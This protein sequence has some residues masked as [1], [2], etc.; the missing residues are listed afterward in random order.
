MPTGCP[1]GTEEY[2]EDNVYALSK[3]PSL[4]DETQP[5][6]TIRDCPTGTEQMVGSTKHAGSDGQTLHTQYPGPNKSSKFLEEN[7]RQNRSH[8][9]KSQSIL[10]GR[11]GRTADG[12]AEGG[13]RRMT[14]PTDRRLTPPTDRA[15]AHAH[16]ISE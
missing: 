14:P 7:H 10:D 8:Q 13:Q 16:C 15:R 11:G 4:R 6:P 2:A 12:G 1:G 5:C 9:N 3:Y